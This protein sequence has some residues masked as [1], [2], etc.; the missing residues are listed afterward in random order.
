MKQ[1]QGE[2]N[3]KV[4]LVTGASRR[5]GRATALRLARH[6]A[7]VVVNARNSLAEI[8][9][10]AEEIRSA[11]GQAIAHLCDVTDE[12]GVNRMA[13]TTIAT[14]GGID[15]LV[16]NAAIRSQS[17]FTQMSF[18]TWREVTGPV[19]DGAFFCCR[20]AIPLMVDRS[21]GV[22]INIGG[23]TG[24]TGAFN[25]AHVVTAKA[26]LVGLTKALAVE[27]GHAG[28]R[29][30]CVVPGRI[31]GHRS[32]TAGAVARSNTPAL[33]PM[34]REGTVDEVAELVVALVLS[35]GSYVT[36]QTI[37]VNGGLYLP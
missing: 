20:A 29:V 19:L 4:A 17:P 21:G 30:N 11:G 37:H 28:I 25:R 22:I 5:S 14:F 6:G 13:E 12:E 27:F 35:P 3:G 31:G 32:S 7:A 33:P 24:H 8:E 9:A 18:T 36:G 2:L 23:L 15:I 26:G 10:V 1:M 16:N 34:E